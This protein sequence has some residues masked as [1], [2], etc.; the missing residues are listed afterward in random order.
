MLP[1]TSVM[2]APSTLMRVASFSAIAASTE[3]P[4]RASIVC[5]ANAAGALVS[6][7]SIN[8]GRNL[9]RRFAIADLPKI[10]DLHAVAFELEF[11]NVFL[12]DVRCAGSVDEGCKPALESH[13]HRL[14]IGQE[15]RN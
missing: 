9:G 10:P 3:T 15:L 4:S 6:S 13:I 14:F 12:V 8:R 5:S 2:F 11:G 7:A 1:K